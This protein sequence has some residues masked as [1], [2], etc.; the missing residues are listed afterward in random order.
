MFKAQIINIENNIYTIKF[1]NDGQIIQTLE[2]SLLIYFNCNCEP[3][4]PPIEEVILEN[5]YSAKN[6]DE[7][8]DATSIFYCD[9]LSF[10]SGTQLL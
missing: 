2:S 8:I 9:S 6:I 7:L 1:E 4:P 3:Y 5:Q 10:L